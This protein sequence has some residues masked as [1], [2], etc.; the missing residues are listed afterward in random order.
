[1]VQAI[2]KPKSNVPRM[3]RLS[4][5]CS[6]TCSL[7]RIMLQTSG[8]GIL[9]V[10]I[11]GNMHYKQNHIYIGLDLHKDSHTGVI[12]NCWNEKLD[13]I[14]F[15]NRPHEFPIFLNKVRK[16]CTDVLIP[17][18]GLE[19]TGGYGRSLAVFLIENK[20]I[21][22]EVNSALSYAERKSY[23]NIQKSDG[24]DA[25]CI[26][27]V[28]LRM[29]ETLPTANPQDSF[30]TL[31]QL[32]SR[33]NVMVKGLIVMNN[34]LHTQLSHSYP[35]Y[36]E[37]F[38]DLDSNVAVAFWDKYPSPHHLNGVEVEEL[39]V[40]LRKHSHNACS[41]RKAK[42]ILG[43][44]ERDGDTKREL[45]EA[46][47]FLVQSIIA[48]IRFKKQEIEKIEAEL[49][50]ILRLMGCTLETMPG[51]NTVTAANLI[52]EIGD[53]TR[54]PNADKLARFSGIAPVNFSSA[55]KGTDQ[56][57]KQGNRVLHGIFYM[58][59]IQ[60]VQVTPQGKQRNPVFYAYYKRKVAEGKSKKQA[61]VCV[62]RR[63]V[64]IIYGM[65]K[66]KTEYRLPEI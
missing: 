13:E 17:I 47:D 63:L 60:Q 11:G 64:N 16:Y 30:W 40:H 5:P 58:L 9:R 53:I 34:Q 44:V 21:V 3:D 57:S 46:R 2:I 4:L 61:L 12:I 45:Q 6:S 50:K 14:T 28:L 41:T 23:P 65:L 55:G 22:K 15:E 51:I 54:F 38:S 52:A 32:V 56:K 24:W 48:D 7:C 43:L 49:E 39:A 25:F 27:N 36:K 10:E 37:F 20:Q 19:D 59:A 66:N 62:M 33:R 8:V 42:A 29:L 18:F 31:G 26:A 1:M 35:S